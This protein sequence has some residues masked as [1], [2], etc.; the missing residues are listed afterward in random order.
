MPIPVL[1][2]K[3][4]APNEISVKSPATV[5]AGGSICPTRITP[6]DRKTELF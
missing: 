4:L 2:V 5:K 3:K 6:F 1:T